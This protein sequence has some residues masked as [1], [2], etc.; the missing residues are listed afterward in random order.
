MILSENDG[1]G[2]RDLY[3]N[4]CSFTYD[5]TSEIHLMTIHCVTADDGGLIKENLKK[6][7]R[8]FTFET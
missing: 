2:G 8:K 7:K 5:R 1:T 3:T 4:C 6:I